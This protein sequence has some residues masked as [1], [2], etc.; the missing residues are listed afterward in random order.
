MR[1]VS[2]F[3]AAT[4][5]VACSHNHDKHHAVEEHSAGEHNHHEDL[6]EL[7]DEQAEHFGVKFEAIHSG[8]FHSVIQCSG[9]IERD[10]SN[11][12]MASAPVSGVIRLAPGVSPGRMVKRGEKLATIDATA[13][14]GGDENRVALAALEAAQREFQRIESL[15]AARLA[16]QAEYNAAVAALEQA[17]AAYSPAASSGSVY[18]SSTG[19]ITALS[20]SDGASVSAGEQIAVIS[21]NDR[22]SLHAE[23]PAGDLSVLADIHDA[24]IGGFTLSEHGGVRTGISAENGYACVFFTFNNDGSILPGSGV[25]VHL[26]GAL[27]DNVMAL[28]ISAVVEQQGE[29][30]VYLHHSP[31]HYV[32]RAVKLGE[33]DGLKV[34]IV[35]GLH[36]GEK[37][38]TEG[39]ITVRLAESSGAIP[40]GHSHSH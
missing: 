17:E 9:V 3:L 27:R 6:I 15:Y 39:A 5:L 32:K 37:V 4:L 40:E 12:T 7:A 19:V 2:I 20:V 14:S 33:S 34:E 28:P 38:V 18:A 29:Y 24:R 16:T 23:V 21:A 30:F 31:G 11:A 10:A 1:K 35:Q 36:D 26:L 8:E 22:L 13:V 25:N